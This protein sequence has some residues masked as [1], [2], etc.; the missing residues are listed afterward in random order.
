MQTAH[1]QL[2]NRGQIFLDHV[3]WM[4]PDI[5]RASAALDR[6]GLRLTPY[7]I[8]ANRDPTTGQLERTG[9]ANRLA[10]LPAGYLEIL[11][12]VPG[13]DTPLSRHL[14]ACLERYTGVHLIAFSV[15]DAE[16]ASGEAAQRGF[17]MQPPA[18]LRRSVEAANGSAA[19][20]AFTV[21]RP[22]FE[23]F[24]EG[25]VQ[26]LT[27][28]TPDHMW[29][30][31]YL[32]RDTGLTS[33]IGVTYSVA[34]P[35]EVASRFSRFLG[36]PVVDRGVPSIEL[37]RGF[38]R[39]ATRR[40]AADLFAARVLPPDPCIAGL[41]LGSDDLEKTNTAL[42][43]GGLHPGATGPGQLLVDPS[44]ALGVALAIVPGGPAGI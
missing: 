22:A 27:H 7:S 1:S 44:E 5:E 17:T 35:V 9:T 19:E 10:M 26:I 40:Q 3:G 25:R 37:D 43:A 33:L 42:L 18:H 24:P 39:F 11:T 31:R 38:V 21:S 2:P 8:H 14:T 23:H 12:A 16:A 32:P 34:D 41:T 15:A 13:V 20:V 4:V 6:L 30:P 36:R 28:H 29:Q